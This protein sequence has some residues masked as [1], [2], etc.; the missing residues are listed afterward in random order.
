MFDWE[1]QDMAVQ[2]VSGYLA[3]QGKDIGCCTSYLDI[4]PSIWYEEEAGLS[5]VVVRVVRYPESDAPL[6]ANMKSITESASVLGRSGFFASVSLASATMPG[7]PLF[8]GHGVYVRFEGLQRLNAQ[9]G[10]VGA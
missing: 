9:G 5:W 1:M 7:L 10:L 3:N 2:V 6:P 8:R 4:D